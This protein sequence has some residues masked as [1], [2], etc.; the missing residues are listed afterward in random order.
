MQHTDGQRPLQI[1][2]CTT[3]TSTFQIFLASTDTD[4][5]FLLSD[6]MQQSY[7]T[8]EFFMYMHS[9]QELQRMHIYVNL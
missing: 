1:S 9:Y 4:T 7:V 6:E 5:K 8:Q 3:G 2:I